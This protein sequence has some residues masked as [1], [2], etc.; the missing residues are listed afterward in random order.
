MCTCEQHRLQV[1]VS[2]L[3]MRIANVKQYSMPSRAMDVHRLPIEECVGGVDCW[4]EGG[5]L[6][7]FNQCLTLQPHVFLNSA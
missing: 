4:M 7:G 6:S 1:P 2:C 3:A 5:V